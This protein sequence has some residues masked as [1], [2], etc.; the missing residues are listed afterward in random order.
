MVCAVDLHV[1]ATSPQPASYVRLNE[2]P[3]NFEVV[4]VK[5]LYRGLAK[6]IPFATSSG[7]LKQSGLRNVSGDAV[8]KMSGSV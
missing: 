2:P 4:E 7:R 1:P 3:E 5:A 6:Q 8:S